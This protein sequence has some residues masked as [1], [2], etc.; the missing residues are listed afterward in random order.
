MPPLVW[1]D[2]SDCAFQPRDKGAPALCTVPGT[3][4]KHR[5]SG[6]HVMITRLA[7]E[8]E[9]ICCYIEHCVGLVPLNMSAT[10]RWCKWCHEVPGL[11]GD[12]IVPFHVMIVRDG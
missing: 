1:S 3:V 9:T 11:R 2:H 5:D 8:R 7:I 12:E 6:R 10:K 4:Q